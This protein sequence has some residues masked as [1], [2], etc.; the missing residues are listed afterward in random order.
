M[1]KLVEEDLEKKSKASSHQLVMSNLS[2][3]DISGVNGNPDDLQEGKEVLM[4]H[5]SSPRFDA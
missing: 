3:S 5:P 1:K 2:N 4:T